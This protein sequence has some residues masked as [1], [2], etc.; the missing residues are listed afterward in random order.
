MS[1]SEEIPVE[2][3][4]QKTAGDMLQ[5]LL[6]NEPLCDELV[7][8]FYKKE[9]DTY[10]ISD[11]GNFIGR[12]FEAGGKP[13]SLFVRPLSPDLSASPSA[14]L[15]RI[16]HSPALVSPLCPTLHLLPLPFPASPCRGVISMERV[17]H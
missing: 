15:S 11:E 16:V 2:K 10:R 7:K 9:D 14:H 13:G 12:Y 3:P 6:D 4:K 8:I 5:D 1:T 17:C